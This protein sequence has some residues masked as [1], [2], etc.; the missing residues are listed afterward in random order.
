MASD[1]RS[2]AVNFVRIMLNIDIKTDTRNIPHDVSLKT[3]E[4]IRNTLKQRYASGDLKLNKK[5][6]EA[7]A[8]GKEKFTKNGFK[9]WKE[10]RKNYF[11]NRGWTILFFDETEVN[12]INLRKKLKKWI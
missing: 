3:K 11:E 12:H 2:R 9:S 4:K 6:L 8:K 5:Q 10:D 7:L 1:N